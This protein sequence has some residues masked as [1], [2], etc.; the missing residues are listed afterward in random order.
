MV[1]VLVSLIRLFFQL[2]YYALLIRVIFSF[3]RL[4][5]DANSILLSVRQF[6]NFVTESVLAPIRKLVP[7]LHLGSGA[8]IDL[9]ALI[10]II[11]LPHLERLIIRLVLLIS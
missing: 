1:Y 8:Y 5:R 3:V 10:L 2:F 6:V 11:F 4:G 9:S 7:P